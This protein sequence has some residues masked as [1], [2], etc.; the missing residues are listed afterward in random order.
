MK[1]KNN[2]KLNIIALFCLSL[3]FNFALSDSVCDLELLIIEL[4]QDLDDNG[5]LDCLREIKPP[6]GVTETP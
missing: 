5:I 4:K 6:N 2:S 3:M 1:Y